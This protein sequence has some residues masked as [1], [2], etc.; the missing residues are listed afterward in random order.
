MKPPRWVSRQ[1]VLALHKDEAEVVSAVT[2]LA[3]GHT[4]EAE[5]AQW[6][7]QGFKAVKKKPGK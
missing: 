4:R 7:T 3:A 5:F 1:V 6:L 2:A